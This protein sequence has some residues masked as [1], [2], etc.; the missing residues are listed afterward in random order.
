[1]SAVDDDE[2][3]Q[4]SRLVQVLDAKLADYERGLSLTPSEAN[5]LRRLV[6]WVRCEVGQPPDEMVPMVQSIVR[7]LGEV[8]QEGKARLAESHAAASNVPKYVRA[9]IKALQKTLLAPP[10]AGVLPAADEVGAPA[11]PAPSTL[12][13]QLGPTGCAHNA[14]GSICSVSVTLNSPNGQATEHAA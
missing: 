10:A 14:D 7:Q 6:G 9:A 11:L 4:L 1:M 8:S 2:V 3:R 12:A 13:A 5:H